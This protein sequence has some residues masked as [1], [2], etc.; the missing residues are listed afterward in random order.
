MAFRDSQHRPNPAGSTSYLM[1]PTAAGQLLALP[2]GQQLLLPQHL[3]QRAVHVDEQRRVVVDALDGA[4]A[5]VALAL[6]PLPEGHEQRAD[7]GSPPKSPRFGTL[8]ML[9]MLFIG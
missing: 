2:Q 4:V 5:E 9:R 8:P 3:L 1:A 7:L 6:P